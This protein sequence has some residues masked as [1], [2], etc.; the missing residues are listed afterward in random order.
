MSWLDKI[1]VDKRIGRRFRAKRGTL[2]KGGIPNG[3]GKC[4]DKT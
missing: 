1:E 3:K 2:H 4:K